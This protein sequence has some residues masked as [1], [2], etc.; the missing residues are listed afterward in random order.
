M[1]EFIFDEH[2]SKMDYAP[3]I[4]NLGK[5]LKKTFFPWSKKSI[6]TRISSLK[7]NQKYTEGWYDY[8]EELFSE[9]KKQGRCRCAYTCF[10]ESTDNI[11]VFIKGQGLEKISINGVP[12]F[13]MNENTK[14][15]EI[16]VTIGSNDDCELII[17]SQPQIDLPLFGKL[18]LKYSFETE[19]YIFESHNETKD[20]EKIYNSDSVFCPLHYYR[21]DNKLYFRSGDGLHESLLIG[22]FRQYNP[23]KSSGFSMGGQIHIGDTLFY[24]GN[25]ECT[26]KWFPFCLKPENHK[27][28][29]RGKTPAPAAPEAVKV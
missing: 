7:D 15:T 24:Q 1:K 22:M 3:L 5:K 19:F 12:K 21:Q 13:S 29:N 10:K 28:G 11:N 8:F 18:T 2:I 6:E 9:I 25:F 20:P 4:E 17:P 14:K 26:S 16:P 27:G 23:Y